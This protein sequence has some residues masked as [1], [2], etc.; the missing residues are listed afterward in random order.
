[1]GW[2]L[3]LRLL[4]RFGIVFVLIGIVPVL[5]LSFSSL[6]TA[7]NA[8][9]ALQEQQLESVRNI[10]QSAVRRYLEGLYSQI[11]TFSEDQMIV[12]AMVEFDAAFNSYLDQEQI[13]AGQL[14]E[15]R[16]SLNKYYETVFAAQYR[17]QTGRAA[18]IANSLSG[19]DEKAVVFQANFISNNRYPLGEK[20]KLNA[21][22]DHSTYDRLHRKY[23]PIVRNY[24]EK[25]GY[26]D[27]FLVSAK[28]GRIVYSVFKEIDYGTSLL[29]GPYASSGI[30]KS[31]QKARS[32]A[33]DTV[34]TEDF[35]PYFPSYD[36]PAS[37]IS[38]PIYDGERLAGVLIFQF[39]INSLNAIMNERDGM[40]KTGESYLVG[41]D[42]LMRS[43]SYLS[44]ESHSVT[45][46]FADP[47]T[48][49]V[50]TEAVELALGGKTGI[51]FI[52]DY[53]GAEVLS[54]YTP[55]EM[56]QLRWAL[57]VEI[58]K[59]E[60]FAPYRRLMTIVVSIAC[61]TLVLV[62]A[63]SFFFT[64]SITR[65]VSQGAQLA[66]A[67]AKGDLT[68]KATTRDKGEIGQLIS[69]LN[70]TSH[71]LRGMIQ[72]VGQGVATLSTSSVALISTSEALAGRSQDT[73]ER[74][75]LVTE[76]TGEMNSNQK[77][78]ANSMN[79]LSTSVSMVA[80]AAEEMTATINEISQ[81]S[82]RAATIATN[83]VRRTESASARVDDLGLAAKEIS[84]VTETITEISEQTN[85]LALNATIEAARAGD[86][87]KGFAVVAGE[88]KELARQ[89]AEATL[90]IQSTVERIQNATDTTV[91]E[92]EEVGSVIS[93]VDSIV[94][95]IAAAVEEQTA[96]TQEI[97]SSTTQASTGLDTINTRV[98]ANS[99]MADDVTQNITEVAGSVTEISSSS[100]ILRQN[101]ESLSS[102][103]EEL[104]TLAARF[105]V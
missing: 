63:I 59:A 11:E 32:A 82:G 16:Q 52:F 67:L 79:E 21:L 35:S 76:A 15:I 30:G 66:K 92:I 73:E 98:M 14:R 24:L 5:A 70:Q 49:R 60:A 56:D 80:S 99:E 6:Q 3:G 20:D 40:G 87:G 105:K 85:L 12:E 81:S 101:A 44:P 95:S 84:K 25:F 55:L 46:S 103:A 57:L 77:D 23:H 27:I 90:T 17:N 61:I 83:A 38:S 62:L 42:Y 100:E 28:D 13:D 54:A 43:D 31:F 18:S 29:T 89:T 69:E 37:F 8:I 78:V 50:K 19:L 1:M 74:C 104:S 41:G 36:A 64:R 9:T 4:Y 93:E 96:T 51:D 75:R 71:T 26:Y 47:A 65:P 2:F 88:I 10:K 7:K 72:D 97:A 22:A 58:D 86:A 33:K 39:P 102:L 53:N 48:G 45:A 94:S 34:H 68:A 91:S